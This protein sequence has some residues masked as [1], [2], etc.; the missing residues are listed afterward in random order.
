M[1]PFRK[2][3]GLGGGNGFLLHGWGRAINGLL[4]RH[5]GP[6]SP[7]F[8]LQSGRCIC[9]LGWKLKIKGTGRRQRRGE[10]MLKSIRLSL[11]SIKRMTTQVAAGLSIRARFDPFDTNLLSFL[12][13][14]AVGF[15]WPPCPHLQALLRY[16][17]RFVRGLCKC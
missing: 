11:L 6:E 16:T 8:S 5:C 10:R 15:L 1:R 4:V 17:E 3:T 14:L 7:F 9:L 13:I 12:P 2:R